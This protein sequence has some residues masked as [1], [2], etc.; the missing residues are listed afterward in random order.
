[1]GKTKKWKNGKMENEENG[2]T[3]K[4][5]NGNTG[6][7]GESG[8]T[9]KRET[10]E[11]ES[12]VQCSGDDATF[13][14]GCC[15]RERRPWGMGDVVPASSYVCLKTKYAVTSQGRYIFTYIEVRNIFRTGK[16]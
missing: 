7:L 16:F 3:G 10:G 2:K 6:K 14:R 5:E 15:N 12:G 1:M 8:K 4:R 13:V 9:G 11:T